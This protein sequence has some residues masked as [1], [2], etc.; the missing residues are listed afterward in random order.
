MNDWGD[1]YRPNT[2]VD[3]CNYNL[4]LCQ[5]ILIMCRH[6]CNWNLIGRNRFFKLN[7]R[8]STYLHIQMTYFNIGN[9][10]F[11]IIMI[12]RANFSNFDGNLLYIINNVDCTMWISSLKFTKCCH[13]LIFNNFVSINNH[14]TK[15]L[16]KILISVW[17]ILSVNSDKMDN[18]K[19]DHFH[20]K[21]RSF[22]VFKKSN[23]FLKTPYT[24]YRDFIGCLEYQRTTDCYTVH[25][26][27]L[28]QSVAAGG[29]CAVTDFPENL[30]KITDISVGWIT[31]TIKDKVNTVTAKM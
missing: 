31:H 27:Y 19:F 18:Y 26:F 16:Q 6:I 14:I 28:W 2:R 9:K 4:N 21:Y 24:F 11:Y 20:F 29:S 7:P 13:W 8:H 17:R 25:L 10:Q 1:C 22:P 15:L 12:L 5:G 3:S 30:Q 23:F